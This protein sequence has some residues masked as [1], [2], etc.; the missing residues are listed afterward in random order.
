MIANMHKVARVCG[1][2]I[3]SLVIAVLASAIVHFLPLLN[4]RV[5][6]AHLWFP[7]PTLIV[8][9]VI[10]LSLTHRETWHT[11]F[12]E[13]RKP[14]F[15]VLFLC[16]LLAVVA[17]DVLLSGYV[18]VTAGRAMLPG[19]TKSAP[20]LF[21]NLYSLFVASCSGVVEEGA[22]RAHLQLKIQRYTGT[23]WANLL[24]GTDFLLMHVL[25]PTGI[26][27]AQ[28]A[29]LVCLS[30]VGGWLTARTSSSLL[31]A[32]FHAGVNTSVCVVVLLFR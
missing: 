7:L 22:F 18:E 8:T 16:L 30:L 9:T 24:T 19:D 15:L 32:M 26:T 31:A 17:I 28:A 5:G 25:D 6:P 12:K 20:V 11:A 27:M 1:H 13:I 2:A 23:T 4:A 21:R 10:F 29:F 14:R 3:A